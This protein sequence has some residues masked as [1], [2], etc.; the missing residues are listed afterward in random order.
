[1]SCHSLPGNRA[2]IG[3]ARHV[4]VTNVGQPPLPESV[5]QS[6]FH[7]LTAEGRR[8]YLPIPDT[9]EVHRWFDEQEFAAS[10]DIPAG[11]A[12]ETALRNLARARADYRIHPEQVT[13]PV[14]HAWS[15]TVSLAEY[16]AMRRTHPKPLRI[17]IDLDGCL[18]DFN[19][20][21]REWLASR[22]WNPNGMPA[23]DTYYLHHAWEID[24]DAFN[25]EMRLS[26]AAGVIFRD[27]SPLR[28]GVEGARSLGLA[29]H[30]LVVNSARRLEG[31]ET[32]AEAA[33]LQWVRQH[34][35]H[36]D[37]I[38]LADPADP[39]DKLAADWDLLIDDHPGNVRAAL[40]AGRAA[41]LLDRGWNRD[42]ADLPRASYPEIAANPHKFLNTKVLRQTP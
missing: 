41:V 8:L 4:C 13:G 27:G 24:Q 18:Y 34:G 14:F 1:M 39:A 20:V 10:I 9:H 6:H 42:Q 23:P 15:H 11:R 32:R 17:A 22:G 21:M 35:I 25:H 33:T 16:T 12:R 19:E 31:L 37:G 28:D 26:T 5:V 38:H 40:G 36:P 2:V 7:T 3:L 29:G 30:Q